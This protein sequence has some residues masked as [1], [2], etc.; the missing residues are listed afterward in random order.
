MA[1]L[2]IYE[3]TLVLG[4]SLL[5][6]RLGFVRGDARIPLDAVRAARVV[7]DPRAELRGE[8]SPGT[9]LG[10]TAIGSWGFPGGKDFVALHGRGPG[11]VVDLAGLEFSRLVYSSGDPEADVAWIAASAGGTGLV[12]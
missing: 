2:D 4:L 11:V 3:G 5:E 10:R 9:V 7:D 8:R 12:P 1:R 6:R